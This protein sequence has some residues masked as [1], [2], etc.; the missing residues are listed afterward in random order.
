MSG[1]VHGVT[2]SWT[3][4]NDFHFHFQANR[5]EIPVNLLLVCFILYG[6]LPGC[7]SN[8]SAMLTSLLGSYDV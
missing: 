5:I 6:R 3:G 7:T 1:T 4:L 8:K 2:K